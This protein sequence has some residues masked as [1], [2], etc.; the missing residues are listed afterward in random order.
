MN[1]ELSCPFKKRE[2]RFVVINDW[3]LSFTG[4]QD[5]LQKNWRRIE[6]KRR[7]RIS[8]IEQF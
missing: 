2:T 7:E 1:I 5:L 8:C 4:T 6:F 3:V